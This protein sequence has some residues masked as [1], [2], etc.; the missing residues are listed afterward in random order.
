MMDILCYK[1]L[2]LDIEW[3]EVLAISA[4]I[5]AAVQ[6]MESVKVRD[7]IFKFG[8]LRLITALLIAISIISIIVANFVA[9]ISLCIPILTSTSFYELIALNALSVLILLYVIFFFRPGFFLP[10]DTSL[11]IK[12]R[13]ELL[14]NQSDENLAALSRIVHGN[15]KK[16]I[17]LASSARREM[18]RAPNGPEPSEE[19][20]EALHFL[21]VDLSNISFVKYIAKNNLSFMM[22]YFNLVKEYKLWEAGGGTFINSLSEVLFTDEDSLLS[23]ELRLSG[24]SGVHK[25]LTNI[26]FNS[27][28]LLSHYRVFQS[29][30][31]WN[32]EISY[33]TLENWTNGLEEALRFYFSEERNVHYSDTPNM[34]LS[35]GISHLSSTFQKLCYEIYKKDPAIW[36][37]PYGS[38]LSTISRFFDGLERILVQEDPND[39]Y[40]PK[41]SNEELTVQRY[42]VTESIAKALFE[43]FESLVMFED[44]DYARAVAM[45]PM[46]L[47]FDNRSVTILVNIQ[48]KVKD[49]IKERFDQEIKY[50][51]KASMIKL[52]LVIYGGMVQKDSKRDNP[53]Q[54]H[55][56]EEFNK[57]IAP[58]LISDKKF[59]EIHLPGD[60]E[61]DEKGKA[62]YRTIHEVKELLYKEEKVK[63]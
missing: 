58:N 10:F 51:Y 25:P 46:W 5:F 28:E 52:M 33:V 40:Q 24:F 35:A 42:T 43:N 37:S 22:Y 44:E 38:K 61:V 59:R 9:V 34:T 4:V 41:F 62:I 48:N 3:H 13:K 45:E 36:K 54:Q 19:M 14:N 31:H 7:Y 57:I 26:L 29:F 30:N 23:K 2:G 16:I 63:K 27:E 32:A 39:E 11:L 20:R 49:L 56:Q 53:I 8:W 12:I 21:E 55:I 1:T 18:Y 50:K 47:V 17:I 15:L 6:F 60:W